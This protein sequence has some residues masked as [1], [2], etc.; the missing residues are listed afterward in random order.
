MQKK[1]F[2]EWIQAVK[3]LRA[4]LTAEQAEA[5]PDFFPAWAVDKDY[6]VDDRISYKGKAY[7]V[8]QAHHSQADWTPDVAVS[9]FA[10]IHAET[11]ED[12]TQPESTN[13]YNKGDKVRHNGK[14]WESTIDG[15]IWEPGVYGWEEVTA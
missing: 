4:E 1:R 12:W 13:P 3:K 2:I 5:T 10:V 11:I 8:L 7:K 9:L 15:N 14:I 6:K